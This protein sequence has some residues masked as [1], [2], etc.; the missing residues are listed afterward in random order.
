MTRVNCNT[1]PSFGMELNVNEYYLECLTR[2]HISLNTRFPMS[3][4]VPR[5]IALSYSTRDKQGQCCAAAIGQLKK[6]L[7]FLY[8]LQCLVPNTYSAYYVVERGIAQW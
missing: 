8:F 5:I 6:T 4:T 7:H 3:C 2:K 1:C